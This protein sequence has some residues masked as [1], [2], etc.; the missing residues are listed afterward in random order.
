[1]DIDMDIL[2]FKTYQ[3]S[4]I[5]WTEL[6]ISGQS[7]RFCFDSKT[8]QNLSWLVLWNIHLIFPE[9][10]GMS[11]SQLTK[12]NLFQR[13]RTTTTNHIHRVS[14]DYPQSIHRLS[15][16]YPCIETT[17]QG[18]N[19]N[20]QPDHYIIDIPQRLSIEYPQII[21]RLSIDYPQSIHRVSIY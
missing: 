3:E 13:G 10:L 21:H 14:I 8:F 11:S 6:A 1:M 20:H 12:S 2:V 9:I 18:Q 19:N 15:I 7:L 16:D 4:M 5:L 17:N